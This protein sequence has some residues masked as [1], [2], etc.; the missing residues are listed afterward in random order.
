MAKMLRYHDNIGKEV[1]KIIHDIRSEINTSGKDMV[2]VAEQRANDGKVVKQAIRSLWALEYEI[3]D[4]QQ[5]FAKG[6]GQIDIGNL[7]DDFV[8]EVMLQSKPLQGVLMGIR[9]RQKDTMENI[10]KTY[11][12]FLKDLEPLKIPRPPKPVAKPAEPEKPAEPKPAE[13]AP[14]VDAAAA[15]PPAEVAA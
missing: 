14:A 3:A 4:I 6:I 12:E 10:K 7:T 8:E 5:E 1:A 15:P 13:P 11:G 2:P 9:I